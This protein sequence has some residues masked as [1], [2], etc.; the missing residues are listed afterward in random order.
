M[1]ST[2]RLIVVRPDALTLHALPENLPRLHDMLAVLD[3]PN[4]DPDRIA[5]GGFDQDDCP[6]GRGLAGGVF[7]PRFGCFGG[8]GA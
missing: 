3:P 6:Q 5:A 2:A 1:H 4:E 7:G 8:V